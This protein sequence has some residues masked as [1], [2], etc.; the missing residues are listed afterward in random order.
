[1]EPTLSIKYGPVGS[2]VSI[3]VERVRDQALL[4][5]ADEGPGIPAEHRLRIL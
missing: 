1:L 3:R 4:T 5:I 2:I